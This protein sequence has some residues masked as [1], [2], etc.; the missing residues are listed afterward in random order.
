M[1]VRRVKPS[2]P[3]S[4]K[5]QDQNRENILLR[6]ITGIFLHFLFHQLVSCSYFTEVLCHSMNN[7]I[8][9]LPQ[10]LKYWSDTFW[11]NLM[12]EKIIWLP[13]KIKEL[14][15]FIKWFF[16][17]WGFGA[18]VLLFWGKSVLIVC[19]FFVV[20]ASLGICRKKRG[21]YLF[22]CP[23]PPLLHMQGKLFA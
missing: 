7:A 20:F 12:H 14:P 22:C 10:K 8:L 6:F 15:K 4:N 2:L 17:L 3:T 11:H 9:L 23:P 18:F 1:K 19:D 16:W 5:G 13:G 21:C